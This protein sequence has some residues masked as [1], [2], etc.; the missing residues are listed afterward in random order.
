M[1]LVMTLVARDEA[2]VMEAML[3]CH[4]ALG[5]D[6]VIATDNG[7]V[8]GTTDILRRYERQRVLRLISEPDDVFRQ[9]RWVTWM[10]RMAAVDYGADWVLN[11]DADEF[12]WPR[13][14]DLKAALAAASPRVSALAVHRYNFVVRPEDDRPFHARMLWRRT[15]SMTADG[16]RMGAKVCHRAD[17][18]VEVAEGNHGISGL[19]GQTLDDGRIEILHYPLRTYDQYDRKVC[20]GTTGRMRNP[21]VGPGISYHW[22]RSYQAR[23][24]GRLRQVW[25]T[26][27]YDD[28]RLAAG[29]ASG[30]IVEDRRVTDLLSARRP[31]RGTGHDTSSPAHSNNLHE[32]RNGHEQV[33]RLST[34]LS[35]LRMQRDWFAEQRD[36][37]KGQSAHYEGVVRALEA[38]L[39]D[40]RTARGLARNLLVRRPRARRA[41][42]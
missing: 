10:A 35:W 28:E 25:E 26:W 32:P 36:E 33:T 6:L 31:R 9:G 18:K 13:E 2:D 29:L 19:P 37:F 30:D 12:W 14:G 7:S 38:E 41:H 21:E 42:P 24:E 39:A 27:I 15:D 22:K 34:E 3:D 5:V 17:A 40:A 4:L 8:D 11:A 20:Q 1:K 23:A 16:L